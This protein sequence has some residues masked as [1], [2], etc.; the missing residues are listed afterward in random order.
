M[1]VRITIDTRG[2]RRKLKNAERAITKAADRSMYELAY[3][4]K[5]YAKS[6]APHYTGKTKSLIVVRKMK[7]QTNNRYEVLSK[8]P[9]KND[10]HTRQI[11]NFNLVRWMHLTN[12][13]LRGRQHIRSGDPQYMFKT[14]DYLSK[15]K[16]QTVLKN[17][18]TKIFTRG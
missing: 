9:T 14:R 2:A 10:G 16:K 12:G 1:V 8:N 3:D 4:G 17:F 6:I 11:K 18:K 5:A 13:I 15:K 7:G